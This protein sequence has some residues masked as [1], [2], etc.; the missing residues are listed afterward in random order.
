[1]VVDAGTG[2]GMPAVNFVSRRQSDRLRCRRACVI[3]YHFP[4]AII[5]EREIQNTKQQSCGLIHSIFDQRLFR[6][7][8]KV[9]SYRVQCFYSTY[10]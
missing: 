9:R 7:I 5:E 2:V 3:F 10:V 1:M 4:C 6:A 8:N